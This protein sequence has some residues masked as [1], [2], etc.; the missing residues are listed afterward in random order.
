MF[1][2]VGYEVVTLIRLSVGGLQMGDLP[3]GEWKYLSAAELE[4][5]F[6]G[7][8]S[9]EVLSEN[10]STRSEKLTASSSTPSKLPSVLQLDKLEPQTIK[11]DAF[12]VVQAPSVKKV[13]LD[14]KRRARVDTLRRQI[15][16]MP[17]L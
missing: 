6:S 10:T 9:E 3:D 14:L 12:N 5:V 16:T 7:P 11:P 13:R 8:S 2:A 4:A 1:T 15:Q 17:E